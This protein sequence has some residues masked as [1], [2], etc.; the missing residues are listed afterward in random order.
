MPVKG[1]EIFG[2]ILFDYESLDKGV[3]FCYLSVAITN[4]STVKFME[5]MTHEK[6]SEES[7]IFEEA[8]TILILKNNFNLWAY[9]QKKIGKNK[10]RLNADENNS[11]IRCDEN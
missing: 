5:R 3:L 1:W 9:F 4:I 8:F 7:T 11:E 10:Q 2:D 6:Y